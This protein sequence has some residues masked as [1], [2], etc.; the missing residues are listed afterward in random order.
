MI[1]RSTLRLIGRRVSVWIQATRPSSFT[2]TVA[3]VALGLA[4]AWRNGRF[5]PLTAALTL[6]GAVLLQAGANLIND[7]MDHR[8]GA[9]SSASLGPSRV[10]QDGLLTPRQVLIEACICLGVGA[11]LG[12]GLAG[13]GGWPVWAIGAIGILIAV[14]Y[15]AGPAPLAYR[16]LGEIA[17]FLAM[18]PGI[19]AGAYAVQTQTVTPGVLLAATPIGLL[20]AAILHAN[21]LRDL[22]SDRLAG[23]RTLATRLG[24][25]GAQVEYAALIAGA[26]A[27]VLAGVALGELPPAALIVVL[28][29]PSAYQLVRT[30]SATTDVAELNH[31]LRQTATLHLRFGLLLAASVAAWAWLAGAV[32]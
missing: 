5:D 24:R 4:L 27:G 19:V 29:L 11:L 30:A 23:K 14:L 17:V 12:I 1:A 21:N 16:G 13:I 28:L 22:D 15:T 8:T 3:P 6:L 18:G 10:I 31:V 26:F 7:Y 9:D 20:V 32:H 2:A 25:R